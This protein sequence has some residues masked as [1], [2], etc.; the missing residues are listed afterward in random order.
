M[1]GA[2]ANLSLRYPLIDETVDATSYQNL[3]NDID[4]QLTVANSLLQS[5]LHRP[6]V[7]AF[8][9]NAPV[10]VATTTNMFFTDG[11]YFSIP[12]TFHSTSVNADQ[13][14]VPT[15]GLYL[16]TAGLVFSNVGGAAT[17]GT[18]GITVNAVSRYG[19]SNNGNFSAGFTFARAKGLLTL[20]AGD[21]V[22]CQSRWNG[23]GTMLV[24]GDMTIWMLALQ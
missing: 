7:S 4:T 5:N 23:T 3:A 20:S 8:F 11:N 15:T 18:V 9:L 2:T 1:P 22:R 6:I 17:G 10:T 16:A 12:S 24:S 21:I 14:I 19:A 13:F